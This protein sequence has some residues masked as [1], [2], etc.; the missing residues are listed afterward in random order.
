MSEAKE[1]VANEHQEL[2]NIFSM[3]GTKFLSYSIF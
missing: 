3:T 1:K 2:L